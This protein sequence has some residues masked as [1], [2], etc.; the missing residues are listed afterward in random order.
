MRQQ[1]HM[2]SCHCCQA[3]VGQV[4]QLV[5]A[6]DCWYAMGAVRAAVTKYNTLPRSPVKRH[7]PSAHPPPAGD[8]TRTQQY[9]S[10]TCTS[11]IP[12]SGLLVQLSEYLNQY[13]LH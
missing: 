11:D 13:I 7:L 12:D 9:H 2:V 6:G 5:T 4:R 10:V 1:W 8:I 3:D